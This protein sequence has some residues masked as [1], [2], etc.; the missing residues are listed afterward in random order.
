MKVSYRTVS[1]LSD[2]QLGKRGLKLLRLG[3]RGVPNLRLGKRAIPKW[4]ISKRLGMT[5]ATLRH[6]VPAKVRPTW[7]SP[8]MTKLLKNSQFTHQLLKLIECYG[9]LSNMEKRSKNAIRNMKKENL[10]DYFDDEAD[11][12]F[13]EED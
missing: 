3:K 12:Y 2:L 5:P 8:E 6:F 10:N 9:R 7:I 1:F 13:I 4:H 11:Y